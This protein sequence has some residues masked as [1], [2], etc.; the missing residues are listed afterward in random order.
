MLTRQDFVT[1]YAAA[2]RA[3][4]GASGI[5]PETI[6]AAAI[7][8]SSGK[9]DGVWYV[10]GSQLSREANNYFGIKATSSWKGKTYTIN[11]REF[12]KGQYITIPAKFRAYDT[13]QDS[14]ADYVSFLQRN[15]RYKKAGVFTAA[16]ASEQ[17]NRIAAAGYAT[18]PNYSKLLNSI[19]TSI[20]KFIPAPSTLAILLL[21]AG[22][23]YLINK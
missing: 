16:T 15:S 11:T 21:V 4:A 3:A 19:I 17:V 23:I 1:K 9:K 20:R 12:I 13:V 6:L 22:A 2:A 5:F 18:D 8:E 10:G 7:L 14:F